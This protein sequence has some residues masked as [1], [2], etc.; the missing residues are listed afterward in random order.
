MV[1]YINPNR[2]VGSQSEQPTLTVKDDHIKYDGYQKFDLYKDKISNG[3]GYIP[4]KTALI[5]PYID[6]FSKDKNFSYTDI[7][8]SNGAIGFFAYHQ[9][10]NNINLYDHDSEYIKNVQKGVDFINAGDSIKCQSSD[11]TQITGKSDLVSLF[12]VIHWIYSCTSNFG[13]LDKI[14]DFLANL[15]N[16]HLIIEWVSPDDIA[17]KQFKHLNFNSGVHKDA[18]TLQNFINAL[19][20]NF[21][22][23]K[24]LGSTRNIRATS[25][26]ETCSTREVW[27]ASRTILDRNMTPMYKKIN[28]GTSTVF[29]DPTHTFVIKFVNKYFDYDVYEREVYW[30]K[31]FEDFDR[32][33]KILYCNDTDKYIITEYKGERINK[34]NKPDDIHKQLDYIYSKLSEYYCN[35]N[36]I[37]IDQDFLVMNN[38]I[39]VCDFGWSADANNDYTIGGQFSDIDIDIFNSFKDAE[40]ISIKYAIENDLIKQQ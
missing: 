15:T 20:K 40:K 11:I 23:V 8:C 6:L 5:K 26:S 18:Y 19:H 37:K 17:I 34:S 27:I 29:I 14:V 39:N 2:K 28:S 21:P 35:G 9:G 13:S 25:S 3:T 7:G 24:K 1:K 30:L 33:P 31:K 36:D 12:A 32:V 4:I 38:K 16:K 22:Y 10:I